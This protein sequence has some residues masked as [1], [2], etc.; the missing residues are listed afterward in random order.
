MSLTAKRMSAPYQRR[1]AVRTHLP[2]T[3]ENYVSASRTDWTGGD[4]EERYSATEKQTNRLNSKHTKQKT[5]RL[6]NKQTD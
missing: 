3:R 2:E 1:L 5:N 6:S 4:M